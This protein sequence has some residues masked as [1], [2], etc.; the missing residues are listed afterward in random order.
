[1]STNLNS[2][3]CLFKSNLIE[4]QHK[5]KKKKLTEPHKKQR[6][7]TESFYQHTKL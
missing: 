4:K 6:N 5:Q 1:M 7:K 2:F 3:F